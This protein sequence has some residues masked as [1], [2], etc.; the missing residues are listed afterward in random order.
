[1]RAIYRE[2]SSVGCSR[3]AIN[4]FGRCCI[5]LQDDPKLYENHTCGPPRTPTATDG[6]PPRKRARIGTLEDHNQAAVMSRY[7]KLV[8]CR[9]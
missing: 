7:N 2:G 5:L 1:M 9:A 6:E 8:H 4:P 3:L